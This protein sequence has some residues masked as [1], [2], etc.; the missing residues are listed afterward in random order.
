MKP[1][2]DVKEIIQLRSD[3]WSACRRVG[4][5]TVPRPSDGLAEQINHYL[6]V[7]D[8]TLLY[9]GQETHPNSDGHYMEITVAMVGK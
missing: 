8:F 6:Q 4:C 7:H 9:V 2:T 5:D 3:E 1:T